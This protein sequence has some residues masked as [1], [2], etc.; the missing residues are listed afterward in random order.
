MENLSFDNSL[1]LQLNDL[2]ENSLKSRKVEGTG[3]HELL[4]TRYASNS[5]NA[6]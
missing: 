1:T 3:R 6:H 2:S 5:I 4:A